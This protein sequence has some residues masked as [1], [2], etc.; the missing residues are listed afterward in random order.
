MRE[1]HYFSSLRYAFS[2]RDDPRVVC[3]TNFRNWRS[4]SRSLDAMPSKWT[5]TPFAGPFRETTPLRA[6]PFTHIFP[7]G[8]QR[9]ISTFAPGLT[10]LA[11]STRHPPALVLERLPQMGTGN[12]STRSSTATKHLMR[13]W[14]RRSLPQLVLNKSGSKGGVSEAGVGTGCGCGEG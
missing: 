11:V 14:R 10:G 3:C 2:A 9:P 12:S 8:T 6:K 5:R 1:L 13:G 7:L 4:W